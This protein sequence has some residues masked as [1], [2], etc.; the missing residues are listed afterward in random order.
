MIVIEYA[1]KHYQP[2]RVSG[3]T[4]KERYSIPIGVKIHWYY[5]G[6]IA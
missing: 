1:Y 2:E 3:A 6:Y 5:S 4:Q